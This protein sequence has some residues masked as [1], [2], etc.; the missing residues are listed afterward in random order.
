MALGPEVDPGAWQ[1]QQ[2]P[3]EQETEG[4]QRGRRGARSL[5]RS[6]GLQLSPCLCLHGERHSSAQGTGVTREL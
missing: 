5:P 1:V 3:W 6:P 4:R 2:L